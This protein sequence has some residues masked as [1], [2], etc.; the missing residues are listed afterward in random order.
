MKVAVYCGSFN[1]LHIGHLA[2]LRSLSE[3]FDRTYLVVSPQNPFKSPE[4]A[5]SARSRFDAAVKAL[6]RHPELNAVADD[7]E[8]SMP[9]PQYT[10]RTLDALASRESANSFTLAIGADNLTRFS[11]W[12]DYRRILLEY[13]IVV[14][15]RSGTDASAEVGK[16]LEENPAYRIEIIDVPKVDVSSTQIRQASAAEV[17]ALLM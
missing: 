14:F 7:I 16:L 17:S 5:S 9:S 11:S 4:N 2:I 6:A 12:K 10:I 15:P 13:G 8:L 3:M 1:P